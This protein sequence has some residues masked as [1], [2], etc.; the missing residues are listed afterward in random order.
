MEEVGC[1]IS[2][3]APAV[4]QTTGS[5]KVKVKVEVKVKVKVK[6]RVANPACQSVT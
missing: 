6:R 5:M 4:S 3:G 1:K 2:S